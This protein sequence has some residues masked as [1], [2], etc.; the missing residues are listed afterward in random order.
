MKKKT[1][2]GNN[3]VDIAIIQT[4]LVWI[5]EK[6]TEISQQIKDVR[7]CSDGHDIRIDKLEEWH[8]QIESDLKKEKQRKEWDLKKVAVIVAIVSASVNIA[9]WLID[10][11]I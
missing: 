6:L 3:K 2:N 4:D 9:I 8:S 7:L 11:L 1:V 10:K 5:R